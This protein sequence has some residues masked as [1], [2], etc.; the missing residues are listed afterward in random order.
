MLAQLEHL[1]LNSLQSLFDQF[2][3]AGV[4]IVMLLENATGITPSE[5]I[6]TLA[7]WM[8]IS[9][10]NLHPA[11]ILFGGLVGALGSSVGSSFT[12]WAVRL[13]GRPLIN[14]LMHLLRLDPALVDLAESQFQR[15]GYG[16]VLIGRIIP[17]LRTLVTLPAGLARMPFPAFFA[18]TFA[19]TFIWCTL[20]IG[21]GYWLGHEWQLIG[22]Y[23]KQF[24]PY[25]LTAGLVLLGLYF[26]YLRA[27]SQPALAVVRSESE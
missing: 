16:L 7:G 26:Y 5:I 14:R 3:W 17:G 13:G 8:L 19:G 10:H 15:W 6:L 21:A 2:G 11:M 18:A 25:I 22:T 24:F 12:Y 9:A 23:L 4:F 20:L 1:I 27:R